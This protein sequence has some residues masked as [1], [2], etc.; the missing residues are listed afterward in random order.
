[1][2]IWIGNQYSLCFRSEEDGLNLNVDT[3]HDDDV[4]V[5]LPEDQDEYSR[6]HPYPCDFCSRRF[7]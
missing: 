1:M 7:T 5:P 6:L 3:S 2:I 4:M